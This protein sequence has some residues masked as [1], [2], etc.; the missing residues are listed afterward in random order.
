VKQFLRWFDEWT[1][2][3]FNPTFA[4]YSATTRR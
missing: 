4:S 3:A 1:L 2:V